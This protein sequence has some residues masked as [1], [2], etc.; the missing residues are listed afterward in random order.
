[1][2]PTR[3]RLEERAIPLSLLGA[4]ITCS[5]TEEEAS[6]EVGGCASGA[7]RC[8]RAGGTERRW[9]AGGIERRR[10]SDSKRRRAGGIEARL[11]VACPPSD[12]LLTEQG[13]VDVLV[14]GS[15]HGIIQLCAIENILAVGEARAAGEEDK[16]VVEQRG[17]AVGTPNR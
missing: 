16:P 17:R 15:R 3:E 13:E 2:Y 6:E 4:T 11:G 14:E 7:E 5:G 1:M 9:R 10:A 12:L 8:R